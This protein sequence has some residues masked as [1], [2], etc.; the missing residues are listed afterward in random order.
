MK[1]TTI[2]TKTGPPM[3]NAASDYQ[4]QYQ[5]EKQMNL[6]TEKRIK[7]LANRIFYMQTEEKRAWNRVNRAKFKTNKLLKV[8][9]VKRQRKF[10]SAQI[11]KKAKGEAR[12][13][14]KAVEIQKKERR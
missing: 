11:A 8:K 6:D 1:N 5:S 7:K 12:L 4:Y 14:R 3:T 2:S 10:I 9:E 13:K